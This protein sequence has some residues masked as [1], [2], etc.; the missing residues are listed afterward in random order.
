MH[1]LQAPHTVLVYGPPGSGKSLLAQAVAHQAGATLFDLTPSKTDGQYAGKAAALM[2]HM[3]FKAAR[4]LAPS[5]V[6]IED[7]DSVFVTDKTRAQA[8]AGAGGEL[9]NRIK[10]QLLA[11]ERPGSEGGR[12]IPGPLAVLGV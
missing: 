12:G 7:A 5:V 1:R 3:V 6:L 8:L 4:A 2:V 9:A 10:K 11:E